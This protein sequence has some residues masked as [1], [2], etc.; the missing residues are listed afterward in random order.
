MLGRT[1][2]TLA[3]GLMWAITR[4]VNLTKKIQ[5][6]RKAFENI[7]LSIATHLAGEEVYVRKLPAYFANVD[8]AWLAVRDLIADEKIRAEGELIERRGLQNP[9]VEISHSNALISSGEAGNL[10]MLDN[11]GGFTETV[12]GPDETYRFHNSQGRYWKRV[13]LSAADLLAAFPPTGNEKSGS[14]SEIEQRRLDSFDRPYWSL[15]MALGWVALCL[16]IPPR[17]EDEAKAVVRKL[18]HPDADTLDV[19]RLVLHRNDYPRDAVEQLTS[20]AAARKFVATGIP[21]ASVTEKHEEIPYTVW[22]GARILPSTEAF[23]LKVLVLVTGATRHYRD[24]AVPAAD[25]RAIWQF[26]RA[27]TVV[28][29]PQTPINDPAKSKQS[30]PSNS[31]GLTRTQ[32]KIF[33]AIEAERMAGGIIDELRPGERNKRL[34]DRMRSMGYKD[35]EIP[36]PRTFREFFNKGPGKTEK[37]G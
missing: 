12:L 29:V 36:H 7:D 8:E 11:W 18:S 1:W 32:Q 4:N 9:G 21:F 24:I 14:I 23:G 22:Q 31:G 25:V 37:R 20:A 16:A 15:A 27:E 3:A 5:S 17:T 2:L 35:S 26:D 10:V 6:D 13:R 19:C 33:R 28:E 30:A 34:S